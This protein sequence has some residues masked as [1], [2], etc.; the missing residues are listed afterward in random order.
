MGQ[1]LISREKRTVP[2]KVTFLWGQVY[3]A[4]DLPGADQETPDWQKVT[5]LQLIM[6]AS[7]SVLNPW[8][9]PLF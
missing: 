4:D 5:F 9:V 1:K 2:G 6:E 7:Y 8:F 3:Q